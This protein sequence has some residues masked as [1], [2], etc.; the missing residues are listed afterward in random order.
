MSYGVGRRPTE[1]EPDNVPPDSPIECYYS[2]CEYCK[3]KQKNNASRCPS[4][5]APIK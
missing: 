5:G 3:S 2:Y 4:C 1:P